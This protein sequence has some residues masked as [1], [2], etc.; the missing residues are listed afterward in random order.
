MNHSRSVALLSLFLVPV[1][2]FSFSVDNPTD[3]A[4]DSKLALQRYGPVLVRWAHQS[5]SPP[6]QS[7]NSGRDLILSA[8]TSA[9]DLIRGI[10]TECGVDFDEDS[11]A[12]VI[13]HSS[14]SVSDV[15]VDHTLIAADDL[16]AILGKHK[17]EA[18]LLFT[19]VAHSLNPTNNLVF[20]LLS[21]SPSANPSSKLSSPPHLTASAISLVSLIQARNNARVM[22][23]GSLQLFSDSLVHHRVGEAD[24]PAIYRI[25]D[26]LVFSVEILEWSGNSWEPYVADDVQVQFYM[27]SPYVLKTLSTDKKG[28]FHTSFKVPDVYGVFQFKVEYEKLGYTT[29]SLSK[30]ITVRPY[31]HNEYER[32]IPTA[33]PYYGACFTT[34]AGFSVFSFVYLYH[35]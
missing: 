3:S 5:S 14:F 17:I 8:D 32:F 11:S 30:Q 35:K 29:L 2:S 6:P 15:D 23:S 24:E 4:E 9:S 1:L 20:K 22:I 7:L 27:M 26:D 10:A 25:K 21:A 34:M 12:M 16:V 28:M 33:Y 19:G 18:P 13:D 31:R